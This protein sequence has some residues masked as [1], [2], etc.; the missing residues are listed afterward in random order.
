MAQPKTKYKLNKHKIKELSEEN[1]K[2]ST[3][4]RSKIFYLNRFLG[5]V[6]FGTMVFSFI[7]YS[8]VVDKQKQIEAIHQSTKA[9]NAENIELQAHLD[10]LRSF[11]NINAKIIQSGTL[12]EPSKIIEV[13]DNKPKVEKEPLK[14]ITKINS[15]IGY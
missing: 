11:D 14:K 12:G 8:F 7:I 1:F 13:N 5:F 4:H 15:A 9:L 10:Y 6:L 2:H 3:K